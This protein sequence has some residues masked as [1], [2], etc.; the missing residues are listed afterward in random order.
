MFTR[1]NNENAMT[2]YN[3]FRMMDDFERDFFGDPFGYFRGGSLAE[4][5]TDVKDE[6]DSFVL[7][8]DLPGFDKKD[9][10]LD[11]DGDVLT[12]SA[13]RHSEHEDKDKK[14]KYLCCERSYGAYSRSFD[15]S[16]IKADQIKAKY[17]NGVL[18][19][20]MPK[21]TATLP[22]SRRLEIE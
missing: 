20:T 6:G 9:V 11:V 14:G 1:K 19:L 4:F 10:H 12:V 7:E 17:E 21:K 8:A 2:N 15:V 13:E 22:Q 5:K 18:T 16:G 3:P